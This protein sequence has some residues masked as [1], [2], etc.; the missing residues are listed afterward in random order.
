MLLVLGFRPV[1]PST[2]RPTS[3]LPQPRPPPAAVVT[4]AP[5]PSPVPTVPT[6]SDRGRA[7]SVATPRVILTSATG[8]PSGTPTDVSALGATAGKERLPDSEERY[9]LADWGR[10]AIG[11][12]RM[13]HRHALRSSLP[14]RALTNPLFY[15]SLDARALPSRKFGSL[16]AEGDYTPRMTASYCSPD[17][18]RLPPLALG[19]QPSVGRIACLL[20]DGEP[21][22]LLFSATHAPLRHAS[23][24]FLGF[25]SP[26][27]RA[28]VFVTKRLYPWVGV[29]I[30]TR[31]WLHNCYKYQGPTTSRLAVRCLHH[32]DA[33]ARRVQYGRQRRLLWPSS[34]HASSKYLHL[35]V[36]WS[37]RPPSRHACGH[38]SGHSSLVHS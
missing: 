34:G 10:S 33:L 8:V 25:L 28:A 5:T 36:H 1:A 18:Q 32:L 12:A 37:F 21:L 26:G 23:L 7:E 38:S 22:R 20:D 24:P 13:Q 6:P 14:V 19:P 17:S 35:A 11:R 30:C 9:S 31:R 27:N 3:R 29:S 15:V 4:P 2:I 16:L